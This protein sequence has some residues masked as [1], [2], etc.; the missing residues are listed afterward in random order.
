MPRSQKLRFKNFKGKKV[1][2]TE[3]Q[4]QNKIKVLEQKLPKLVEGAKTLPLKEEIER[5]DKKITINPR[6]IA[7]K[8]SRKVQK[9]LRHLK[10]LTKS[11]AS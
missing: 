3:E 7:Q 1:K 8:S 2:L 11:K 9:K 4:I 5:N 6:L 10:S